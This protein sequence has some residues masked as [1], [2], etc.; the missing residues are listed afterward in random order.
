MSQPEI[1]DLINQAQSKLKTVR[2]FV[3]FG[4]SFFN[5]HSLFYGHGTTNVYD[6]V[7]YLI[8]HS[9][10]LPL[11]VLEPFMDATILDSEAALI[12]DRFQKRA[13]HHIPAAY[14]TNE[15]I[16]QGYSF[17]VDERVIIPRSFIPEIMVNNQL[18]QWIEH[19]ELIHDVLDL[20]TG[21]GSIAIIAADYF[22]D[23]HI[24]AA[25]IDPK[26]LEVAA[27]NVERYNLDA[28]IEL[29]QTDLWTN[30]PQQKFD[31]ILSNPPYVDEARMDS[32]NKEY[33]HEPQHALAG[34]DSGLELVINILNKAHQYLN[35]DGILV[36]EMGDNREE[37]ESLFPE[38][39]FHW[40]NTESGDGFV[41]VLTYQQLSTHFS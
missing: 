19:E 7:V 3:R 15:A 21:N 6:E 16:I 26:A 1:N 34:G 11:D 35:D 32:L 5:Q 24:I 4:V 12:L 29:I 33:L 14:L 18:S 36:V 38:L 10:N 17:Y 40:I 25:D 20:C 39:P 27:I 9:L 28:Q 31:L 41:F 23:S 13:I 37:L 2:D 8:L 22:P 30:I